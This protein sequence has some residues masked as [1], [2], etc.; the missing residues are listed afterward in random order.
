MY[1]PCES[2]IGMLSFKLI[3]SSSAFSSDVYPKR[4]VKH[5]Y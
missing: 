5:P 2:H 1:M 4:G 3:E